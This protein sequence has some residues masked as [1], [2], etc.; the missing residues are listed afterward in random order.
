MYILDV[1]FSDLDMICK[2]FPL[3]DVRCFHYRIF[4]VLLI[5]KL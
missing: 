1:R 5:C 4:D 2:N 3:R